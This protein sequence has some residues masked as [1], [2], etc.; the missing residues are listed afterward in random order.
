MQRNSRGK[1]PHNSH[2]VHILAYIV[3]SFCYYL[4]SRYLRFL[5]KYLDK[6]EVEGV[7]HNI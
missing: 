4:I 7:L 1:S 2:R 5:K 3:Y 6:V